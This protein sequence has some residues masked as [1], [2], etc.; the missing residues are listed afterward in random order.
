LLACQYYNGLSGMQRDAEKAIELWLQA[1]ELGSSSACAT[2][3]DMYA[4][5]DGQHLERNIVRAKYYLERGSLFGDVR[6]RFALGTLEMNAG[7]RH[8]AAKHWMI[9]AEAGHSPSLDL[10]K[11]GYR[12]GFVTKDEYEHT[13]RAYKDSIDDATSEQRDSH[14]AAKAL[15][16]Q[17]K[18]Q[19]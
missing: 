16:A 5:G 6:A 13:L 7:N 10:T 4:N 9:A 19:S 3:G 15:L 11:I 2:I 17:M 1:A 12:S 14:A 18:R 8:R